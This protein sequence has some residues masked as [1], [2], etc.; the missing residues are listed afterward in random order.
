MQTYW[1]A[2]CE[3][4]QAKMATALH[5]GSG[6]WTAMADL[7]C[8]LETSERFP[9]ALRTTVEARREG[10]EICFRLTARDLD[11][12]RLSAPEAGSVWDGDCMEVMLAPPDGSGYWHWGVS[13]QGRLAA[14]ASGKKADD[15]FGATAS[16]RI[17]AD[18]YVVELRLPLQTVHPLVAGDV[19]K[20]NV[21]RSRVSGVGP[22]RKEEHYSI[23]G[24]NFLNVANYHPLVI[25][26]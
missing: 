7:L 13:P 20:F 24:I 8:R 14:E 4:F 18:R 5:V 15:G 2:P 26:R 21:C 1:I 17:L 3:A 19:W 9:E 12:A 22:A 25:E 16:S 10:D 6:A 11:A 23:G